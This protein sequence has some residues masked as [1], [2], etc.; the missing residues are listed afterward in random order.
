MKHYHDEDMQSVAIEHPG[1]VVAEKFM[2][3]I[4]ELVQSEGQ[5]I[6]S[7]KEILAFKGAPQ[8]CVFQ[9]V[10]MMVDGDV[11]RE[12]KPD[13]KRTS[14]VVFIGRNLPAERIRKEFAACVA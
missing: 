13:E 3:W 12:W 4:N 11:Q 14:R 5:N 6:F 9:G 7:S 10:H 2:P 1:E 8:R